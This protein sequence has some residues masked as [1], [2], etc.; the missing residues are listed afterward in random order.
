MLKSA[1][2]EEK[3]FKYSPWAG[4]DNPLGPKVWCQQE[5]LITMVIC[6]K[7]EKNL[8]NLWLYTHLFISSHIINVY[9]RR[10][11]T[12]NPRGQTFD[13]SRTS[14]HFV[15][16][17]QVSINLFEVW[18]FFF[19][20]FFFFFH[21]FIHVYSPGAG[22]DNPLGT[23]FDVNRNILFLSVIY[24]KFPKT[25]FEVWFYTF[26]FRDF[27][28]VSIPKT[29]ADSPQGQ[30]FDV[31]RNNLSLYSFVASFKKCVWSLILYN[32]FHDLIHVYS[33]RALADNPQ[34]QSF[35][36]NRKALSLY[37]FVSSFKEISLKSD[38]I[39]C[40]SWFNTCI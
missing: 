3:K 25:L 9:S 18:F 17:L 33:P 1:V 16:L 31:N 32:F 13:V 21:D 23:K 20:F 27:I 34:W 28:H 30:S 14:C 26:L 29:G 6:C 19:F 37:P 36:V 12:D 4:A 15:H 38:F 2:T 22:A 8:F 35:D 7:F 5:G 40:F 11:G 39:Q 24:C 10:S